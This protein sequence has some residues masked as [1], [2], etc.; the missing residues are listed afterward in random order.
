[1]ASEV[2][3]LARQTEEA[4][5]TVNAQAHEILRA[6]EGAAASVSGIGGRIR[7]VSAIAED[8]ATSAGQQREA[9][10]EI[11]RSVALAAANTGTVAE[12]VRELAARAITTEDTAALFRDPFRP[13][14][15]QHRRPLRAARA[16]FAQLLGGAPGGAMRAS[17]WACRSA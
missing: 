1:M 7:G 3:E 17:R 10:A 11:A 12:R 4:I 8:V 13:R 16:H 15:P 6:T 9:T 14:Q 2:K 5:G